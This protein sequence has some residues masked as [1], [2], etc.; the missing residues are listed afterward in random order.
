[1]SGEDWDRRHPHLRNGS[2][3]LILLNCAVLALVLFE[4]GA[5]LWAGARYLIRF[6]LP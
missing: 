5:L 4:I 3:A 2:L 1:M 6:V